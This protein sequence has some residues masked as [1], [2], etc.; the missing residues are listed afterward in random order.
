MQEQYSLVYGSSMRMTAASLVSFVISQK[1]DVFLFGLISKL[2]DGKKLWLRNNLANIISQLLD[3]TIFDFIAF[4]HISPKF[5]AQFI[6]S[7]IIPYWLFKVVFALLD[8]PFC[9]LGVR[10]LGGKK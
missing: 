2:T 1:L 7:M 5:N 10:W 4:W 6:I 8:T 3:T 9:Y